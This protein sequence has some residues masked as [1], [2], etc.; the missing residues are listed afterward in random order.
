MSDIHEHLNRLVDGGATITLPDG[1]TFGLADARHINGGRLWFCE[2]W[3]NNDEFAQHWLDPVRFESGPGPDMITLA[4]EGG[5]IAVIA[6]MDDHEYDDWKWQA[7]L[8][9]E[10]LRSFVARLGVQVETTA[11]QP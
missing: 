11:Q 6:K 3:P 1:A 7:W 9:N 4:L 8:E 10:Q 2:I 5:A